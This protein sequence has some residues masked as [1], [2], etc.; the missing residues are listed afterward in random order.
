MAT[1]VKPK[2]KVLEV[3]SISR[4]YGQVWKDLFNVRVEVQGIEFDF[5]TDL[6]KGLIGEVQ[7]IFETLNY[8]YKSFDTTYSR[9]PK[10]VKR[11]YED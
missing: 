11:M 4:E 8:D 1:Q 7:D 6:K 9:T 3:K 2:V 5:N 10:E